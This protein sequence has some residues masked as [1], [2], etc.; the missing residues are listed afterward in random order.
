MAVEASRI[1]LLAPSNWEMIC[2]EGDGSRYHDRFQTVYENTTEKI[3]P[4][5][6]VT[7]SFPFS[8]KRLRDSS[9]F[10]P[11]L[12]IPNAP[13]VNPNHQQFHAF[14]FIGED[15]SSQIYQQQLEIDRF[16]DRHTEK[17][18]IEIEEMRRRNTRRL[19]AASYEGIMKRLKSKEEQI[20]KIGEINRSLEEKVKAI[21][22]ENQIWRELAET[23]EATANALRNNL[24]QV[25][26]EI[27]QQQHEEDNDGESR[28]GSNFEEDYY[29]G[30]VEGERKVNDGIERV[31][32]SCGKE[33]SCVL[34][35]PCRHLC[36][37][38]LCVSSLNVCPL[39]NSANSA[40]LHVKIT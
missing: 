30:E 10:N 23:S 22:V 21:T 33:E 9:S 39:C 40:T 1:T 35:L 13:I 32:R 38:S 25:L 37:C 6:G 20:Q 29:R 27:H 4:M 31:C 26:T 19:A 5:N 14:E 16:I 28:C 24:Q 15:F 8:R 18:R 3:V 2:D 11:L 7:S 12:Y 34:L 36:V 17:V